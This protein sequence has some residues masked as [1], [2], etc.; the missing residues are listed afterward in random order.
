MLR[1]EIKPQVLFRAIWDLFQLS[2]WKS[3]QSGQ[4]SAAMGKQKLPVLT[5]WQLLQLVEE[6][7]L[8]DRYWKTTA[9]QGLVT[10][11]ESEFILL[12]SLS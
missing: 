8:R 2:I 11:L 7:N 12:P 5:S 3:C 4:G 6:E 9:H 10:W 1:C